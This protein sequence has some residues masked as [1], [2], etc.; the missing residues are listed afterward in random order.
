VP[1]YGRR[2]ALRTL[3]N[4]PAR[5]GEVGSWSSRCGHEE[6]TI[7]T[8]EWVAGQAAPRGC[9][10]RSKPSSRPVSCDVAAIAR[11]ARNPAASTQRAERLFR[12]AAPR[13]PAV[14][15]LAGQ[16]PPRSPGTRADQV[17]RASDD[18][19]GDTNARRVQG[20]RRLPR[21]LWARRRRTL[22]HQYD[23][24]ADDVSPFWRWLVGAVSRKMRTCRWTLRRSS[25]PSRI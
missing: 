19:P 22:H 24:G 20:D 3:G 14:L 21:A 6:G 1:Q 17:T 9:V 8:L 16:F 7:E 18:R 25:R 11:N 10:S 2:A 4:T 5:L 13:P 12:A 15:Q 23:A